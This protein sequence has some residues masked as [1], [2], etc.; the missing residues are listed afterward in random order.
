MKLWV[1][2][3]RVAPM[4]YVWARSVNVAKSIIVKQERKFKRS[5][6]LADS[7]ELL[8]LDHDA[9]V[10]AKDG[11]DYIRLMD[12]LEETGRSY[13]IRLHTMNAV[14]RD[15]MMRIIR[16]NNWPMVM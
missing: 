1:D 5:G 9:G 10:Y 8:D 16:H 7:V 13:P 2:D 14:G 12:W 4:G 6:K 11:G 15:N 3:V